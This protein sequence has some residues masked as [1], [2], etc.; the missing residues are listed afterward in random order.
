MAARQN[1]VPRK[2]KFFVMLNPKK[3][4]YSFNGYTDR[5]GNVQYLWNRKDDD[6]HPLKRRFEFSRGFR[7]MRIPEGQIMFAPVYGN[8]EPEKVSV[9]EFLLNHPECVGSPN[10]TGQRFMFKLMDTDGDAK[11]AIEARKI[12]VKAENVA[13][14]LEGDKLRAV[15]AMVGYRPKGEYSENMATHHCM[16]S[17]AR[18]PE[19]FLGIVDDDTIEMRAFVRQ[20]IDADVVSLKGD[21]VF[22]GKVL[23]GNDEEEAAGKLISDE[24]L[25]RGIKAKMKKLGK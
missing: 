14:T 18:D 24:Q 23:L 8:E 21:M 17:A 3:K 9:V 2:D 7:N 16:E 1:Y 11:L 15:A 13:L 4:K 5:D 6:G 12:K 20:A 22:W 25:Y 10:N 19:F